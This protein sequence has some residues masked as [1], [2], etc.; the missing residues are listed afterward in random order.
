M[1]SK[2]AQM[3][4]KTAGW[5][6]IGDVAPEK[7]VVILEAPHTSMMDFVIGYLYYES[8]GGHLKVM[9]KKE[10]FWWPLGHL[11]KALGCFPIDRRSPARTILSVVHAMEHNTSDNFHMV[12]CP[13]GTRK[14]VSRWKTGYHTIASKAEV[15]VYL[16]VIDYGRKQVGIFSKFTLSDDANADTRRIQKI[17]AEHKPVPRHPEN[18]KT[19]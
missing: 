16:S 15:P 17:Y 13:E 1:N 12:L 4:L 19:E 8:L 5:Q 11:L 6:T 9:A 10:L 2:L 14:A 18:F 7:N 3:L